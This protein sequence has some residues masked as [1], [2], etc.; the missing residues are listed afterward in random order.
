M[1]RDLNLISKRAFQH[2]AH[3]TVIVLPLFFSDYALAAKA[4]HGRVT[5]AP[6]QALQI[7]LPLLE[8]NAQD[9]QVLQVKVAPADLWAQAGLTPPVGLESLTVAL[10]PGQT[11]DSR[12]VVISSTQKTSRSPVDILLEVSTATGALKIQSSYLVLLPSD[13][14]SGGSSS[15]QAASLS[16]L[17]VSAGDTL[18]GIAQRHAVPGADMY[19]MLLAIYEANPQAFIAGNMNLLRAGVGLVIPDADTI[20]SIDAATARSTYQ[21]HLAAF[22][23]RR[24]L[25]SGKITPLAAGSAGQS[26]TVTP[27]APAASEKAKTD[28]LRLSATNAADQR[29]DAKVSAAKEIEEL[30][31]RIQALQQNV[32]KLKE[33][34]GDDSSSNS[35]SAGAASAG[36]NATGKPS[37]NAATAEKSDSKQEVGSTPATSDATKGVTAVLDDLSAFLVKNILVTITAVIALC[38]LAIAWILRRAGARRDEQSDDQDST[39]Q[40]SPAAQSAFD[41][42]LHSISLD[43]DSDPIPTKKSDPF[44][45][46]AN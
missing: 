13:L 28:H 12:E 23:Q 41:Q 35:S 20:R 39:M 34:I 44:T 15:G 19:Q 3:L 26:G 9:Q 27:A 8:L 37:V 5:S 6:G 38:A 30:Q 10:K 21:K 14:T 46:Q 22:N 2:A 1:R 43:L 36:S 7:S 42:K 24:G 32:Q 4:G 45:R 18:F 31:S 17:R 29:A 25:A 33:T 11:A 40:I 16:S